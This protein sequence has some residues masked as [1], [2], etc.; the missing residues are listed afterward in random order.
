VN[1]E[2]K[3][4]QRMLTLDRAVGDK[5]LVASGVS[6]GDRVITEGVQKVQAGVSVKVIPRDAGGK[7][8]AE[9]D[10]TVQ[11]AEQLN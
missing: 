2:G 7:N 8:S 11:E 10:K 3:V 4:E 9:S 6:P 1:A 5:W